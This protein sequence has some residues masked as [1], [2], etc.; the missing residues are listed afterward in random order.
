MAIGIPP[1]SA[2]AAGIPSLQPDDAVVLVRERWRGDWGFRGWRHD[3]DG[4]RFRGDD[5]W[6][7]RDH[8]WRAFR[9]DGRD[10]RAFRRYRY[11]DDYGPFGFGHRYFFGPRYR[12]FDDDYV[13]RRR[14]GPW[15]APWW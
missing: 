6:R 11:L 2:D 10:W 1:A 13:P 15:A 12:Y 5:G 8:G 3:D 7:F 14:R 9:D 4:W